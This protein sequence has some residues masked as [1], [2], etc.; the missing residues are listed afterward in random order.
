M[1]F[2][3]KLGPPKFLAFAAIALVIPA[4]YANKAKLNAAIN[5]LPQTN[6][7]GAPAGSPQRFRFETSWQEESQYIVESIITDLAEMVACAKSQPVFEPHPISVKTTFKT[8]S[9]SGALVYDVELTIP[10]SKSPI[11]FDL[12]IDR[13]IWSPE[14]YAGLTKAIFDSAGL[15]PSD[16]ATPDSDG[17]RLLASLTELSAEKI[18]KEN[19]SLS[20]TLA[21][22][23]QDAQLHEEA[24][25]LLGA[26][27]LRDSSRDFFDVRA[28]LCRM[29][30]HL[31]FARACEKQPH[32]SATGEVAETLLLTL[33]NNQS[34]AL[35][36][37]ARWETSHP[38]LQAWA[39][40]LR[41]RNT[42]D[43]RI[44]ADVKNLSVLEKVELF[45]ARCQSGDPDT[46]WQ[47]LDK[48][49]RIRGTDYLRIAQAY[50]FSVE[51]G[52]GILDASLP[53]EFQEL[54]EVFSL[55]H[56]KELSKEKVVETLNVVPE[57]TILI[58]SEPKVQI[59]G[60]GQ[61]ANF[62]QRHLCH[63]LQRNFLFLQELWG[64][65]EQAKEFSKQM[66]DDFSGLRLYPFVRRFNSIEPASY[67][68]AIDDAF[69]LTVRTPH[70]IPIGAWNSIYSP[71]K[72]GSIYL[73]NVSPQIEAW[74]KEGFP[75]MTTYDSGAR[76][77]HARQLQSLELAARAETFHRWSPYDTVIAQN[78]LMHKYHGAATA[79]QMEEVFGPVLEFNAQQ[80][81]SLAQMAVA[82]PLQYEK[83]M[84]R[85][86]QLNP[87]NYFPLGEYFAAHHEDE[88]AAGYYEKGM[89]LCSDSVRA[90]NNAGWLVKYYQRKGMTNQALGLAEGAAEVYSASGLQTKADLMESLGRYDEALELYHNIE[91][92]YE[93]CTELIGF[94][95]RY[96]AKTGDTQHDEELNARLKKI[97]P[98][99]IEKVT[100]K[101]LG[102]GQ[103]K[104]G[105]MFP[106]QNEA[107]RSAGL[108]PG[109]IVVAVFGI[110]AHN[111]DQYTYGRETSRTPEMN[112]IV[113]KRGQYSEI[114]VNLPTRRFGVPMTSFHIASN[115]R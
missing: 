25:L 43:Y 53:L 6:R 54:R 56:S 16:S 39:R 9:L 52:H 65:P 47:K 100:L 67:R 115:T 94:L 89:K 70:L 73:P 114:T 13:A 92:R 72:Y 27:M 15:Q 30:A 22:R 109:A 1:S 7:T 26:F 112:L 105:V 42:H 96:K 60:W 84:L 103:P 12:R 50:P 76:L 58:G 90:A 107:T 23:F 93:H 2:V 80:N 75:H 48:N 68:R 62:A 41:T 36:T 110:R 61:W 113:W 82:Q 24:A 85:A 20:K 55:A 91:D 101:D 83:L 66:D 87:R 10:K 64:V 11:K 97:F 108:E 95:A 29:T 8:N 106:R 14:V 63:C 32:S 69:A 71:P 44:L 34:G 35:Q 57:Q 17:S 28:P 79:V 46:A 98:N 38:E 102:T 3:M 86:A 5:P 74:L 37:I 40:A 77:Y 111:A 49:E 99:G 78:Y 19:L 4:L 33:V 88:K 51:T 104:D 18:Q 21:Q 31:A 81:Y 59:I 45:R